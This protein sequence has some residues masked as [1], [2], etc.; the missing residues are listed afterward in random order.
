MNKINTTLYKII[1]EEEYIKNVREITENIFKYEKEDARDVEEEREKWNKIKKYREKT[2]KYIKKEI[3][4]ST[5]RQVL[6]VVL[7][8]YI[9]IFKDNDYTE[10]EDV[11]E[12]HHPLIDEIIK[13]VKVEEFIKDL[14]FK[15][16]KASLIILYYLLQREINDGLEEYINNIR[17]EGLI[18]Y[19]FFYIYEFNDKYKEMLIKRLKE[20][21]KKNSINEIQYK[22]LKDSVEEYMY[23]YTGEEDTEELKEIL[24]IIKNTSKDQ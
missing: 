12:V 16:S 20:Y 21:L 15:D 6:Y 4:K 22:I 5:R 19:E 3:S 11:I 7:N 23:L 24:T 18:R 9:R 14:C 13:I 8:N 2:I 17:P 1:K 10:E